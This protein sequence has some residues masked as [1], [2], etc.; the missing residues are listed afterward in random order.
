MTDIGIAL[1]AAMALTKVVIVSVTVYV[2]VTDGFFKMTKNP[3]QK[4]KM[5]LSRCIPRWCCCRY[6]RKCANNV[7]IVSTLV[8]ITLVAH[9]IAAVSLTIVILNKVGQLDVSLESYQIAYIILPLLLSV[10]LSIIMA[11]LVGHCE[12]GEY[13]SFASEQRPPDPRDWDIDVGSE[14]SLAE[15]QQD[16][17]EQA[18]GE[19]HNEHD[20]AAMVMEKTQPLLT[21]N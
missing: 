4:L 21:S 18:L 5:C 13:V 7:Y 2:K 10:Q 19:H 8:V 3:P 15:E 11:F 1:A 6:S 17:S 9:V 16:E 12:Q 20:V 14:S